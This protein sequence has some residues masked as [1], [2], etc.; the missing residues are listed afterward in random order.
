MQY[1]VS[2]PEKLL[3]RSGWGGW[4][5]GEEENKAISAFSEVEV[6]VEAEFGNFHLNKSKTKLK[7]NMSLA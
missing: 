2:E 6:E 1:T 5:G 7:L 3:F 4:V